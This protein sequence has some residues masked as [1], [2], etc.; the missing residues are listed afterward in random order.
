[1]GRTSTSSA[2]VD[3]AA[4]RAVLEA[5]AAEGATRTYAQVAAAA[6]IEPPQSI[7]RLNMALERL[8]DADAAAG[9]PLLAAVVVSRTRQGLPAPG[10]FAH[11][12]QLGRYH[13]PERG[14]AAAEFHAQELAAV[15]ERYSGEGTANE[16]E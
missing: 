14:S 8:M 7:H 3:G 4:L 11:A 13:G 2:E 12:R 9:R 15:H 10:F 1:M 5:V 6:G 16:R